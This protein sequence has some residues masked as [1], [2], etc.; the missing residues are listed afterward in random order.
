M[1][2]VASH[3]SQYIQLMN[4]AD[5]KKFYLKGLEGKRI[6]DATIYESDGTWFLF[7]GEDSTALTVLNLWFAD[8]PFDIF[9]PHPENPVVISPYTARMGGAV[10]R[11][12]GR[13]MRFG[14][15]N[16]AEYGE[17]LSILEITK[18][19]RTEYSE[20]YVGRITVDDFKGPH[21]LSINLNSSEIL[22]DYYSNEFSLMAGVRRL[23][24][25]IGSR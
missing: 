2:E 22:F 1:P 11:S 18:L 15:D 6:V 3:S 8:S 20:T 4:D 9:L 21:S 25:R 14:Q 19:S 17:A 5:E 12:N 7:F 24:G 16:S 10:L 13:M 23:K